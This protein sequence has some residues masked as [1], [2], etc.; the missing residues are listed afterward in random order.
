[1]AI[2][3]SPTKPRAGEFA[4]SLMVAV[5]IANLLLGREPNGDHTPATDAVLRAADVSDPKILDGRGHARLEYHYLLID[6]VRRAGQLS[7]DQ[8]EAIRGIE[9]PPHDDQIHHRCLHRMCE[10]R[11]E[12][13]PLVEWSAYERNTQPY[14][15]QTSSDS[16]DAWVYREMIALHGQFNWGWMIGDELDPPL[17]EAHDVA[18]YHLQ[19]T[20]PDYTTYQPW[21]LAAFLYFPDTAGFA[22]QQLHDVETHLHVEGPPGALVPG[23]LLADAV[24][25]LRE[26]MEREG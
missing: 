20:Q 3:A 8:Y 17:E 5:P 1:M 19:H 24:A 7:N 23:L 25:T 15:I 4:R 10:L 6:L 2:D 22:E 9:I 14:H 26:V 11:G 13:S 12:I 16:P 21:A 18:R